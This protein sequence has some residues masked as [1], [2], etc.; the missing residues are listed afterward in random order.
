MKNRKWEMKNALWK[1]GKPFESYS[2]IGFV[3][4][5]ASLVHV[6]FYHHF[7]LAR[8]HEFAVAPHLTT[9][10]CP[11]GAVATLVWKCGCV[12]VVKVSLHFAWVAVVVVLVG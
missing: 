2:V 10:N 6:A 4:R 9:L 5:Q 11:E 8:V 7:A 12:L 1:M 3:F